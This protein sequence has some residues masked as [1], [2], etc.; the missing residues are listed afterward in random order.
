MARKK[1]DYI[2]SGKNRKQWDG[3]RWVSRPVST[4][5]GNNVA[6]GTGRSRATRS[7]T[8]PTTPKTIP[9]DKR[10]ADMQKG[11]DKTAATSRNWSNG[12]GQVSNKPSEGDRSTWTKKTTP[13]KTTPPKTTPPKTTPKAAS[14]SDGQNLTQ[15]RSPDKPAKKSRTW[16]A[17]NYKSGGPPKSESLKIKPKKKKLTNKQRKQGGFH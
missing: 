3:R 6:P 10:P 11:K 1:G 9:A 12:H 15:G 8:A 16:L 13:P 7:R 5:A 4:A 2:G 14:A 17:D